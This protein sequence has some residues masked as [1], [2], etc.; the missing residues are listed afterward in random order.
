MTET[1]RRRFLSGLLAAPYVARLGVLM[2][3]TSLVLFERGD[4]VSSASEAFRGPHGFIGARVVLGVRGSRLL[5]HNNSFG[6]RQ[7]DE[8]PARAATLFHG[9]PGNRVNNPSMRHRLIR[10]PGRLGLAY[11]EDHVS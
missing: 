1:T 3:V 6:G 8:I 11:P 2:P 10:Y 4:L 7:V 9:L 5:V